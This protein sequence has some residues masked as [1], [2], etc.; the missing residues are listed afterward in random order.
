MKRKGFTL[1]ELLVVIA[2]IAIL[3]AI[4][5]PVFA[6]A[7]EKARQASCQS[8]QKQIGLAFKMYE[9]DYDEKTPGGYYVSWHSGDEYFWCWPLAPYTKNMQMLLCP[10]NTNGWVYTKSGVVWRSSYGANQTVLGAALSAITDE[11]NTVYVVD[12]NN[13]W[14][15]SGPFIYDRLGKGTYGNTSTRTDLHN[16]GINAL[17]MDGHVKWQKLSG[18][19]YN[20]FIY[21]LSTSSPNYNKPISQA[22]Q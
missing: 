8:N 3:A 10:S 2:I 1:I 15:D 12:S 11:C 7:R 21:N 5:F 22:W 17:F 13:P 19:N 6:R 18:I 20:Q 4:L 9:Q 14:L 16:E